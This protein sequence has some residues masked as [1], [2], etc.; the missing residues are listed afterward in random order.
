[1]QIILDASDNRERLGRDD[2]L[3]ANDNDSVKI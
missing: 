1:M 3:E 2:D